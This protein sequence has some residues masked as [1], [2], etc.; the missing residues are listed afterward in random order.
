MADDTRS[1]HNYRRFTWDMHANY[2]VKKYVND[3]LA[4]DFYLYLM[5]R[6]DSMNCQQQVYY[7]HNIMRNIFGSPNKKMSLKISIK[8]VE[9]VNK[10]YPSFTHENALVNLITDVGWTEMFGATVVPIHF[11]V[12][13]LS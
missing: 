5:P 12:K 9:H 11:E 8:E 4:F 1:E 13:D 3:N 6:D 2:A 10:E 7:L